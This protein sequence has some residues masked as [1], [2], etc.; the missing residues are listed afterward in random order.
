MFFDLSSGLFHRLTG[1]TLDSF[2]S[3]F[4]HTE[5][6]IA[7]DFFSMVSFPVDAFL[8]VS[9]SGSLEDLVSTFDDR[10]T[11]CFRN[12]NEK[13]EKIAPVQIRNQEDI[14]T[15]CQLVKMASSNNSTNMARYTAI[16][17]ACGWAGIVIKKIY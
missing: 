15:D 3:C 9:C 17:V 11:N 14:H 16:Q 5:S 13:T 10:I 7:M 6:L 8:I 4:I 12:F 2:N 1:G